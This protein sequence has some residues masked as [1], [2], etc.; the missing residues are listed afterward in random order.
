MK[1]WDIYSYQPSGWVEAH[2][3]VIVSHPERVARKPHV[4]VIMC[5]TQRASRAPESHEVILDESDGL[6]WPT[7]CKCD[8]LYTVNKSELKHFRGTVTPERKRS[9]IETII[10]ANDWLL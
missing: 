4:T 8:L 5:A 9:I 2:P 7:L 6:D 3:A 10:V 1:A